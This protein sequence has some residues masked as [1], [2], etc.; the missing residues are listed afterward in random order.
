MLYNT[1]NSPSELYKS[2]IEDDTDG[3][4][5]IIQHSTGNHFDMSSHTFMSIDFRKFNL[6]GLSIDFTNS[7]FKGADLR[8]QDLRNCKLDGASLNMVRISGAYLPHC[9]SPEEIQ[10]SINKGTRLRS[11][12]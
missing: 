5:N 4:N 3:F 9:I 11:V 12:R 1:K 7:Y 8:G 6:S 2:I 10:L